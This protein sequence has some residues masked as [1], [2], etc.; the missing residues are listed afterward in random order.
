MR[1][2][3][4]GDLDELDWG[5]ASALL[6]AS[7]RILFWPEKTCASMIAVG[8]STFEGGF[9][10]MDVAIWVDVCGRCGEISF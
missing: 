7:I 10:R 6:S 9:W 5:F 8:L 1:R 3:R 4:T 2:I